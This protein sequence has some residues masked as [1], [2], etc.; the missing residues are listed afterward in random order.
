M[1]ATGADVPSIPGATEYAIAGRTSDA[2]KATFRRRRNVSSELV[3]RDWRR[4]GVV[5]AAA[6][7]PAE[8][9]SFSTSAAASVTISTSYVRPSSKRTETR[10]VTISCAQTA[11][12]QKSATITAPSAGPTS[13]RWREDDGILIPRGVRA[14]HFEC[15]RRPEARPV[16]PGAGGRR[17][18]MDGFDQ[19][20]P[21]RSPPEPYAA[22]VVGTSR[23]LLGR[24]QA[25]HGNDERAG[26]RTVL[27]RQAHGKILTSADC[28]RI[29]LGHE[30]ERKAESPIALRFA[31]RS[32]KHQAL[33]AA[34]QDLVGSGAGP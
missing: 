16:C 30:L 4:A 25:V 22:V 11:A 15:E 29:P 5:S 12:P 27:V 3:S 32:G 18:H 17:T 6:D 26:E 2:S 9:S 10:V 23:Q 7:E 13:H 34:G 33:R 1:V 20:H 24:V 31:R 21:A 28:V 14:S 8:A 19:P